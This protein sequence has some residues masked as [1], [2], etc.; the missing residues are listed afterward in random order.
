MSADKNTFNYYRDVRKT[1]VILRILVI[2]NTHSI[3]STNLQKQTK[4]PR[5]LTINAIYL[6][7]NTDD[8]IENGNR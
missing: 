8:K 2:N 3:Y 7:N 1:L 4:R 5:N 6:L